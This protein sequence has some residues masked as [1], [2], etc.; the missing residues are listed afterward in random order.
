VLENV[1][2]VGA[3]TKAG[4]Q[5]LKDQYDIIGDVRGRGLFLSVELV[6]DRASKTPDANTARQMANLMKDEGVL[7][8]THGRYENTLKIRPPMVFSKENVDQLL[9][10]LDVCFGRL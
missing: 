2:K 8:A 1:T 10:A 4:L 3:Y 5:K 7:I 9:A 6:K